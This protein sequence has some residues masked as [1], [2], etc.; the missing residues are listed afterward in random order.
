[1]VKALGEKNPLHLKNICCKEFLL[2]TVTFHCLL[3]YTSTTSAQAEAKKNKM[4][5]G[6]GP[7]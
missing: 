5:T 6:A 1:L 7:V 3:P 2:E 4:G